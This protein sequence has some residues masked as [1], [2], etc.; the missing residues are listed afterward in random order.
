[1]FDQSQRQLEY[2]MSHLSPLQYLQDN[3]HIIILDLTVVFH[4]TL[5][6]S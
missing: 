5:Y 3:K 2:V 1:M 4:E 6:E